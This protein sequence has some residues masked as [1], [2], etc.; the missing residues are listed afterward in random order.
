MILITTQIK[1]ITTVTV[2]EVINNKDRHLKYIMIEVAEDV[3]KK[4]LETEEEG[5]ITT[6]IT[7]ISK[8]LSN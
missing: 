6:M 3:E 4:D 1:T 5:E 2:E 8:P 7:V